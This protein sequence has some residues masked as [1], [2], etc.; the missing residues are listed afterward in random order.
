MIMTMM[1]MMTIVKMT[2]IVIKMTML[3]T[4]KE[5]MMTTTTMM[6]TTA[7]SSIML[8][9]TMVCLEQ[10]KSKKRGSRRLSV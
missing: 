1:K 9:T 6:T 3:M 10:C 5:M 4:T 8:M 7:L 2:M